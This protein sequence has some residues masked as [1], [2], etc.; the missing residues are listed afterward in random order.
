VLLQALKSLADPKNVAKLAL[1]Y[2]LWLRMDHTPA[3]SRNAL[4]RAERV[5]RKARQVEDYVWPGPQVDWLD[6]IQDEE[7]EDWLFQSLSKFRPIIR[8]WQ[9]ATSLPA[10]Q[11]ILTL[12]QDLFREPADL[13]LSYKL[14]T[15]LRR[16]SQDHP[17]WRLDEL[18]D[19]LELITR[20][21]RKFLGFSQD[22]MGFNPDDHPGQVVVA[23]M[24]RAKGLEWDRVYLL[25][26]NNYDFPF[27]ANDGQFIAEKWFVRDQ[28]NLGAEILAQ[29]RAAF[30]TD[31][32]QWYEPGPATYQ[33]RLDYIR[34]RLRLLY[35]A[36]TRARKEL[37]LTWNTG[38]NG[39]QLPTMA[40]L[41]LG[42]Y[43][44][45][46]LGGFNDSA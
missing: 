20:N 36:I 9:T 43:W 37:V 13:A 12:S 27:D 18:I 15:L 4:D 8:R 23:T 21:E 1:V 28:L 46:Q 41:A 2:R 39:D 30:T 31:E 33:A 40:L 7:E 35:V 38:R 14:G 16:A 17:D 25:S 29:L 44:E 32:Y 10:D 5:L 6:D 3:L 22:D 42:S 19:E 26:L 24:H 11:L 45:D 34:E